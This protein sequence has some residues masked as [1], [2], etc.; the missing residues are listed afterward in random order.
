MEIYNCEARN[1][2]KII[3]KKDVHGKRLTLDELVEK[4]HDAFNVD[5]VDI[6]YVQDLMSMYRSNPQD[7]KKYAKFD[8]QRYDYPFLFDTLFFLIYFFTFIFNFLTDI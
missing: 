6:D 3:N 2:S 8:R 7:W 5:V 1:Y 4:L